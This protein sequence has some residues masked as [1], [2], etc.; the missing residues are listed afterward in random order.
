ML[1]KVAQA[2]K[3]VLQVYMLSL[4]SQVLVEEVILVVEEAVQ[5]QTLGMEELTQEAEMGQ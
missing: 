4:V 5:M 3:M 2:V 1:E